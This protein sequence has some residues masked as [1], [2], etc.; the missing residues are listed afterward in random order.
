MLLP[1]GE[2]ISRSDAGS[3][4]GYGKLKYGGRNVLG[5]IGGQGILLFRQT[6]GNVLRTALS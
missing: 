1:I 6:H 4:T 5:W 2:C 3:G